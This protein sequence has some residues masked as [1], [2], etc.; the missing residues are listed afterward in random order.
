[1]IALCDA[2]GFRKWKAWVEI[3]HVRSRESTTQYHRES[4]RLPFH[5]MLP[6]PERAP[7][8]AGTAE[9]NRV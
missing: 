2:H 5:P 7:S 4:L 6:L 1:M 9:H 8:A 3:Y